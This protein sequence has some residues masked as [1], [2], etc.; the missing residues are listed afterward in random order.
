[1]VVE[2]GGVVTPKVRSAPHSRLS[3]SPRSRSACWSPGRR[4]WPW[5]VQGGE[6]LLAVGQQ[7]L[8]QPPDGAGGQEH[9]LPGAGGVLD[10]QPQPVGAQLGPD[11]AGRLGGFGWFSVVAFLLLLVDASCWVDMDVLP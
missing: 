6:G 10:L 4:P 1:V 8:D 5:R 11:P 2:G 3:L 9:R 7:R